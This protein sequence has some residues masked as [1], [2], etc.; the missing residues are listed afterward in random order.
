MRIGD[1]LLILAALSA[2]AFAQPVVDCKKTETQAEC[3]ARLKCKVDEEIADCQKR[4]RAGTSGNDG[5]GGRNDGRDGGRNDGRDGDRNDGRDG[6]NDGGRDGRDDRGRGDRDGRANR[7]D[8]GSRRQRG[9]GRDGGRQRR[10]GDTKGF[11]SIKTFGLGLELGEPTGLNGKYFL[12]DSRALDFGLGW[13]Y[14]HY[15]YGDGAHVYIDH[16][17]HPA[18]LVSTPS[19]ELPFYIGVGLRFW[20]FEYCERVGNL[21]VCDRGSAFGVRVPIGLSFDFNNKPLDIFVQLV[22]V[23]D[24]LT[25]DFYDRF[26]DRSHFGIDGSVGFRLWFK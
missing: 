8:G 16:L 13:V 4:L 19:L 18:S 6:R 23:I 21:D 10:G 17:W 22:P 9:R 2:P 24:L 20:N 5:N 12:S 3:H 14:S 7:D 15:Y 26:D 1:A 11:Q 25:G